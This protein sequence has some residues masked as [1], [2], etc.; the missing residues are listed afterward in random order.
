VALLF[1][2]KCRQNSM[3]SL[4]LFDL[5]KLNREFH[6]INFLATYDLVLLITYSFFL[7]N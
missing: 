6:D 1:V 7:I 4:F 3:K 5:S 2:Y